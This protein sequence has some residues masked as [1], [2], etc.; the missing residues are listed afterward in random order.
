M[1]KEGGIVNTT[2]HVQHGQR[3]VAAMASLPQVHLVDDDA[4]VRTA[5]GRL[6]DDRGYEVLKHADAAGFLASHDPAAHGCIILDVAMPG[7]DGITLQQMLADRGST[8]P[9]IFLTG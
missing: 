4:S 8:M 6:L 7:F 3:V 2:S 9:V 1:P 5:L